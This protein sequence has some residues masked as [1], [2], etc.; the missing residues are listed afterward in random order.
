[1]RAHGRDPQG[2]FDEPFLV[3]RN[4]GQVLGAER[5][6]DRLVVDGEW[7]QGRLIA[8]AVRVDPSATPEAG[9][10]VGELWRRTENPPPGG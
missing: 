1:M 9:A 6:G 3:L 7:D 5:T 2:A 8:D 10:V 4:Q